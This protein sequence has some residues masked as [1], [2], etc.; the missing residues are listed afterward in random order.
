M[1]PED[2]LERIKLLDNASSALRESWEKFNKKV[3]ELKDEL[4]DLNVASSEVQYQV[5]EL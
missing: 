5:T 2:V 4:T 1:E 3:E